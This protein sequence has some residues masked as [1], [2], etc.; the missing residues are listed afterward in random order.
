MEPI[1][2]NSILHC[3]SNLACKGLD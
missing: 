1:S 2:G 3:L